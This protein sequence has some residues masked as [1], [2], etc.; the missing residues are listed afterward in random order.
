MAVEYKE[1]QIN[2]GPNEKTSLI[3]QESK[4][5]TRREFLAVS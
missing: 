2:I 1:G 3:P 4:R 5:R